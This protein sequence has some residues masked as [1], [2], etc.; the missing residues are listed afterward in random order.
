MSGHA[1]HVLF[2]HGA[3]HGSWRQSYLLAHL[4]A[5]GFVTHTVDLP[6]R[7][8]IRRSGWSYRV[9]DHAEA[10]VEATS[11][12]Q[13]EVL[14]VGRPMGGMVICA[15]AQLRPGRFGRLVFLAVFR[16]GDGDSVAAVDR[17]DA[18]SSLKRTIRVSLPKRRVTVLPG[19]G[20][21]VLSGD[22]SEH[23]TRLAFERLCA[24]PLRPSPDTVR[25]TAARFGSVPRSC[26]R[27]TQD[28]ALSMA[29]QDEML[30]RQP[31]GKVAMPEA[32][33]SP[34]LS[35]PGPLAEAIA[36]VV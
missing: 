15:A 19:R 26:V 10:V 8:A 6:G 25:L 14:A 33:H 27:R 23:Q 34:L 28:K 12:V 21:D 1:R 5:R 18:S 20:A 4:Q 29:C 11:G 9:H 7:E 3:S 30:A 22:R 31:C 16:P 24:E 2:V 32:S 36:A 35:M 13:A 17:R